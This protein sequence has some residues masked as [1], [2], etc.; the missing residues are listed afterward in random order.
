[1]DPRTQFCHNP[2]CRGR[3]EVDQGNIRVLSQK[4]QR[5]ECTTCGQTFA[6]TK[7]TAFYR[8]HTPPAVVTLVVTLL[9]HGCPPQAGPRGHPRGLWF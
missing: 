4:E 9:C 5:Y 6:A 7:G 1:M 3:G 8:L 2:D